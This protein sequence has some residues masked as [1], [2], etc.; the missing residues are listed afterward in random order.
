MLIEFSVEN[1][2]SIKERKT[3]SMFAGS[4]KELQK[5]NIFIFSNKIELLKSA[6]IYG[7]NASGKSNFFRAITFFEWF[8]INS[9]KD[10]Q[11]GE[12]IDIDPFRL[13]TETENGSTTMEMVFTIE[14]KIYRYGFSLN[15]KQVVA[16]WLYL[17]STKEILLFNRTKSEIK[18]HNMFNEGKQLI[19]NTRENA[20]FLSVVAQ[21][22]GE[23]SKE[24]VLWFQRSINI[25]SGLRDM[26]YKG[27]TINQLKKENIKKQ[28]IDYLKSVDTGIIDLSFQETNIHEDDL[29]E[30]LS[31]SLKEEILKQKATVI[32]TLHPKFDKEMGNISMVSFNLEENESEGTKKFFALTGPLI[33]TLENGKVLIIDEFDAR[34]HPVISQFI[35]NLFN[36][37]EHNPKNAQLIIATHDTNL[38]SK[39]FFRRDQIWFTEKDRFG[40]TDLYSLLE[41]KTDKNKTIRNDEQYEKNYLQGRYGAIP[42]INADKLKLNDIIDNE[43]EDA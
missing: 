16:E 7:A 21:F 37:N 9:S 8:I 38:L 23:I 34:L 3:L 32:N 30:E 43:R 12:R 18:I 11:A 26:Q 35:I 29:P 27:Y 4:I 41:F 25:I 24:V 31:N 10:K 19:E 2:K 22:N 20:L 42:F 6:A 13:N 15:S 5:S 1:Y 40:A 28:I 33:D 36:S 14:E 17:T 39:K